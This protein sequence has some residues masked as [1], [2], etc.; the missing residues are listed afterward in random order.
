MIFKME[1][2]PSSR[3]AYIRQVGP[4]GMN[5]VKIME[6]L[7]RWA[8]KNNLLNETAVILGIAHDNPELTPPELCRYDTCFILSQNQAF[9]SDEVQFGNL[10]GGNYIVFEVQHTAEA[11]QTAWVTIFR[12]IEMLNLQLDFLRPILE[13]YAVTMVQKHLCEIC[14]PIK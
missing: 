1:T 3:I 12:E 2:M 10:A 13:R 4:Y 11:M 6:Q 14:V 8:S 5:N 7:K 9:D